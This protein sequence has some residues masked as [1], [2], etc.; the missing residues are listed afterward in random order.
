MLLYNSITMAYKS[1]YIDG[2]KE[3]I[4][5]YEGLYNKGSQRNIVEKVKKLRIT[6][7]QTAQF[8]LQQN[9]KTKKPQMTSKRNSNNNLKHPKSKK[10]PTKTNT[11]IAKEKSA[12]KDL[13]KSE[14]VSLICLSLS[15]DSSLALEIYQYR[16]LKKVILC[17]FSIFFC[18]G[19]LFCRLRFGFSL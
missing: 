7:F 13:T 14:C 17:N 12:V 18:F 19:W 8:L 1:L 11:E 16:V 2:V 5:K 10:Q 9:L 3:E 15:V 4:F 6:N